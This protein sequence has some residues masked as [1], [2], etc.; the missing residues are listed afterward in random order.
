MPDEELEAAATR[1]QAA[2]RGFFVRLEYDG[3]CPPPGVHG[4]FPKAHRRTQTAAPPAPPGAAIRLDILH[5]E[6][7]GAERYGDSARDADGCTAAQAHKITR[8][9][10]GLLWPKA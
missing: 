9:V 10:M 5:G 3:G 1:I 7:G 2:A 6:E 4:R 8:A